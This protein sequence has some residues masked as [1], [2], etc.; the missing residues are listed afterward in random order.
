MALPV[1][2]ESGE[3]LPGIRP[4]CH[5]ASMRLGEVSE[6]S[7]E[8]V[9]KTVEPLAVPGVRIPP[10]PVTYPLPPHA[11]RDRTKPTLFV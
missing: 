5:P 3:R 1:E 11:A 6:W 10:S 7:K 9:L 8:A 4:G 2:R